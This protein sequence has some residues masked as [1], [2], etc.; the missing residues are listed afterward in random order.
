MTEQVIIYTDG[1]ALRNPGRGG[2]AAMALYYTNGQ[3]KRTKRVSGSYPFTTN[4]RM[5]LTAAIQGLRMLKWKYDLVQVYSDSQ[6]LVNAFKN[7][8]ITRWR[9]QG[10]LRDGKPIPNADL[11]QELYELAHIHHVQFEWIRGHHGNQYNNEVDTIARRA[12]M[13]E[14]LPPEWAMVQS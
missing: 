4:N 5:E 10:W 6:Y 13:G 9:E 14:Q 3:L 7:G 12:A 1:C 8:W 2:Y 11:W